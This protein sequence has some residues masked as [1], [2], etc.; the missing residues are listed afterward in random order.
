MGATAG[1]NFAIKLGDGG[2]PEAFTAIGG[3]RALSISIN[4]TEVDITNK[5]DAGVRKLLA[6][7][8][9]TSA[10]INFSGVFVDTA[11][12]DSLLDASVA[13]TIHNFQLE[14]ATTNGLVLA[15]AAQVTSFE[16]TG[17]EGA[18]MLFSATLAS[19]D[20]ITVTNS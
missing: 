7:A 3:G 19:A 5:D 9:V 4:N 11:G 14:E 13:R 20:A 15:L 18:E 6:G 8:G 17:D 10:T 1:R 12:Q 16:L 2:D